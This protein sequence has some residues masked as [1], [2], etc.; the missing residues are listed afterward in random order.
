MTAKEVMEI[1]KAFR[2]DKTVDVDL[3]AIG[4]CIDNALEKQIPKK[5][6]ISGDSYDKG[7]NLIYDTYDCPNCHTSYEIEYEK[8]DYCP[9]CGQALDWSEEVNENEKNQN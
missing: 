1:R 2:Q 7:G 6:D 3:V 5:P 4:V 9:S 8:Y